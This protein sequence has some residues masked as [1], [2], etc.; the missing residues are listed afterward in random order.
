MCELLCPGR[1]GPQPL[2]CGC[3]ETPGIRFVGKTP[4]YR[5]DEEAE[6][7]IV[8]TPGA[9][10]KEPL[11]TGVEGAEVGN[12]VKEGMEPDPEGP[13]RAVEEGAIPVP[14]GP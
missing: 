13:Y 10:M 14:I 7:A 12:P 6:P 8:D 9:G 1:D 2:G 3:G 11:D 4:G 5:G